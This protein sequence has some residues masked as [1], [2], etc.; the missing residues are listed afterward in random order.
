MIH[1]YGKL[2]KT[3]NRMETE[4]KHISFFCMKR[5]VETTAEIEKEGDGVK[6]GIGNRS[7]S[8]R[9]RNIIKHNREQ[10]SVT[11]VFEREPGSSVS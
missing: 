9:K 10:F 5:E 1:I 8:Q 4:R 3:A 7:N 11:D 6:I 2:T